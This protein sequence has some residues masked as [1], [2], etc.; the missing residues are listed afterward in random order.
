MRAC[1]Q[2]SSKVENLSGS[3]INSATE[4]KNDTPPG[5]PEPSTPS[6]RTAAIGALYV[7]FV[8]HNIGFGPGSLLDPG[9]IGQILSGKTQEVNDL[10][11]AV[12]YG[13]GVIGNVYGG[14]L[15][16]GAGKQKRLN[17]A[18]FSI[19]GCIL[20]FFGVGPYLAGREYAPVVSREELSRQGPVVKVFES[21]VFALGTLGLA[22]YVYVTGLGLL[23]PS[24]MRD[25][26][27]YSCWQDTA[28][29]FA[30]DRGIH[31]T[32]LDGALLSVLMW[33]PLTE[34]MRRRG[35]VFDNENKSS[36]VNALSILAAPCLGPALYLLLRP[37]LPSETKKPGT[38]SG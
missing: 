1:A 28:R 33:G 13:L 26:I 23:A 15:A 4:A 16:A 17:S 22:L 38:D 7:L 27:F 30:S 11:I 19:A 2:S 3:E 8:V 34:D 21:K 14:L 12:F 31:A 25:V 32:L 10:V 37:Q 9:T 18:L 35:W 24:E 20:G 29:L 36:F 5:D 6:L